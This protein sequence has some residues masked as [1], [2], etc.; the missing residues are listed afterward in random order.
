MNF[1]IFGIP[2]HV[3]PQEL[4]AIAC[5]LPGLNLARGWIQSKLKEHHH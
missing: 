5:I 2:F 3:C 1:V 4:A